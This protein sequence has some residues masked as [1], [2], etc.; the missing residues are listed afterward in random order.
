MTTTPG[1]VTRCSGPPSAAVPPIPTKIF[2]LASILAEL[3]CQWPMVTP[4]SLGLK[5]C[6]QAEP[7]ARHEVTNRAAII[8]WIFIERLPVATFA[9]RVPDRPK[10]YHSV[11]TGESLMAGLDV[12]TAAPPACRWPCRAHAI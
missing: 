4:A 6:A 7:L 10:R 9:H 8:V 11:G 1:N 3:R 5:G 2:L 12:S